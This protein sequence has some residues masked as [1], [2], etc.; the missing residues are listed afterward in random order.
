MPSNADWITLINYL[1][2][3]ENYY[4]YDDESYDVPVAD[5]SYVAK[6]LASTQGWPNSTNTFAVGNN[7]GTNNASGFSAFPTGYCDGSLFFAAGDGAYFR[8]STQ[9]SS[10]SATYISLSYDG[11]CVIWDYSSLHYGLSVRCIRD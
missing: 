10:N 7:Q 2:S 8:S 9:N 3:H 4:Y 6:A 11:A 5:T 1:G